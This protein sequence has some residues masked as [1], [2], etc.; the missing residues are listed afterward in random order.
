ML[1]LCEHYIIKGPIS[2]LLVLKR[3]H[4]AVQKNKNCEMYQLMIIRD[5]L[6]KHNI[7]VQIKTASVIIV[8]RFAE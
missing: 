8:L 2:Y 4:Y 5:N 6:F 7:N 1:Y 3:L